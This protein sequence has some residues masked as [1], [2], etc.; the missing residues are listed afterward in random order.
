MCRSRGFGELV[1]IDFLKRF[2]GSGRQPRGVQIEFLQW[3]SANWR[4]S[5]F[6]GQLPV[7]SG[8]SAIARAIQLATGGHIITPSNMLID[9]YINEYSV[10]YLKGKA[11]Y[12]C[13]TSGL[14]CSE[15]TDQ[16]NEK[17]CHGCPYSSCRKLAAEGKP[18]FFNPMSLYYLI[19]QARNWQRPEVIIV[20]E[21]HQLNSMLLMISGVRLRRGQYQFDKDVVN[22]IYL[23]QWL[24]K[25]IGKLNRLQLMYKARGD[26]QKLKEIL[27]EAEALKLTFECFTTNPQNYAVWIEDG[28]HYG[29]AEKFL[30][31]KPLVVPA[32]L[33]KGLLDS[34][35]LV[36]MSGTMMKTDIKDLLGEGADYQFSDL[37]SPIPIGNRRIVYRPAEFK[38][39][40]LTPPEAIVDQIEAIIEEETVKNGR[41]PNTIIHVSYSA[42]ARLRNKFSIP[43]IWNNQENKDARVAEFKA[44][45][46]VF[47]AAGCAEGLD[48]KGEICR[49]NIIPQLLFPNL[50]D[51]SVK[52][53]RALADGSEWYA[54]ETM[55]AV[56]QQAGRSTRGETDFSTT[57]ILDNNFGWCYRQIRNQLPK[58]FKEAIQW[59]G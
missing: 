44:R 39:N 58:S 40:A 50:G 6:V 47:L 28:T 14:T 2:D 17:P 48:L 22:E 30:N 29:R 33:R 20:D 45:G 3:L 4:H 49:L 5:T 12:L 31:I 51:E 34:R 43:I 7:G 37:S 16:L 52:K 23:V 8:K 38:M 46:G 15:W 21:A 26:V 57:Y 18:T 55:K 1:S 42:S 13:K 25:Q 24:D 19:K 10:N 35:K 56:I 53:R 9:Q 11:N 36:L 54:L 59:A 32:N 27:R 41:R